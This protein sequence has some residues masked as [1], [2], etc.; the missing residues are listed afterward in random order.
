[1][2]VK[3]YFFYVGWFFFSIGGG[4]EISGIPLPR[5]IGIPPLPGR[6]KWNSPN[7][8]SALWFIGYQSTI[9]RHKP[10]LSSLVHR[11]I[12]IDIRKDVYVLFMTKTKLYFSE[13]TFIIIGYWNWWWEDGESCFPCIRGKLWPFDINMRSDDCM[14]FFP[15][16]KAST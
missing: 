6:L 2:G 7:D 16:F 10:L 1:V 8:F 3:P 4:S 12:D 11:R 13:Y 14:C 15:K 5:Y 9:H